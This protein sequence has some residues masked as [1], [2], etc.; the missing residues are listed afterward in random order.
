MEK[1][2]GKIT[3]L[4]I[5]LL[6]IFLFSFS[7]LFLPFFSEA[8]TLYFLPAAQK[9]YQGES[10][11]SE[12]RINTEGEEIN[13]AQIEIGV[14]ADLLEVVGINYGNSI[15][16]L[17]PEEPTFSNLT[18][19][20]SFIGGVPNGFSGDGTIGTIILKGKSFGNTEISLEENSRVL[21]ND[22]KG[23]EAKLGFLEGSYEVIKKPENLPEIS[24]SSHPDQNKWF[25][26][27]TLH[28]H[29]GLVEGTEYSF[30][31]SQDSLVSP[32]EIPDKPKG[33]LVWI[34]DIEYPDLKDGVY[35]F[36]LRQKLLGEEWSEKTTFRAMV[37]AT[38]AEPFE[39]KIGKDPSMFEGKYFLSF[40]AIDKSSGID[41]YEVRE[42]KIDLFGT[43]KVSGWEVNK[44]PYL[45]KDQTLGSLVKVKAVDRAGN[46]RI[47]EILPLK[48]PFPYQ[49]L[50][51]AVLG[52]LIIGW[53]T[54][55]L[56]FNPKRKQE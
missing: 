4:K 25:K 53:L 45:I 33:E 41:H 29:W 22:G 31:L 39:P 11:L 54:K 52:L 47:A 46:E 3:L 50:I 21:L 19:K 9:V 35:Y 15:L 26:S 16:I 55:R 40:L 49:V 2:Q 36:S 17:W 5:F 48:K 8:A 18:G 20:I 38:P 13:A 14:P 51:I 43:A 30:I 12:L 56:V 32:D 27:S 6:K 23:T 10:F 1:K 42:E 34:G 28:L 24:S 37:D 7:L 44:S